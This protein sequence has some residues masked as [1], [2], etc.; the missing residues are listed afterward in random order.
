MQVPE[1]EDFL[2]H[3][4][5]AHS[6]IF[7]FYLWETDDVISYTIY[8]NKKLCNHQN[9]CEKMWYKR[10]SHE[11]IHI[12][13]YLSKGATSTVHAYVFSLGLKMISFAQSYNLDNYKSVKHDAGALHMI[14]IH[15]IPRYNLKIRDLNL[16]LHLTVKSWFGV[17]LKQIQSHFYYF[18]IKYIKGYTKSTYI[19]LFL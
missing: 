3:I 5:H 6:F 15:N 18:S 14:H 1:S 8:S 10:Q 7:A 4:I 11:L 16:I 9:C 12:M 17:H 2:D 13:S 19:V